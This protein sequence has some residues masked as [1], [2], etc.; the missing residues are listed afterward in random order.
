MNTITLEILNGVWHATYSGDH[1]AYI[2]GLFGAVSIPTAFTASTHPKVVR[3][4]VQT[5]NPD[6]VV[7]IN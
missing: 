5:K 7:I 4:L 6:A 2:R 1:A 3:N